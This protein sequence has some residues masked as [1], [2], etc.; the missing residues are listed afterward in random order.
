MLFPQETLRHF[1]HRAKESQE[2]KKQGYLVTNSCHL[3]MPTPESV[4]FLALL[5]HCKCGPSIFVKAGR[6]LLEG[7]FKFFPLE[8]S[9]WKATKVS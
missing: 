1:L 3:F 9:L 2:A 4:N 5:A 7:N 8:P 6:Q